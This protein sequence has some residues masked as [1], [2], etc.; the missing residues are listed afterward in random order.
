M[1][2]AQK[3]GVKLKV[4]IL[5]PCFNSIKTIGYT[6]E[7]VL[8]QDY[9]NFEVLVLDGGSD[10]GTQKLVE[11]FKCDNVTIMSRKDR[12]MYDALNNGLLSFTGDAVGVLNSDDRYHDSTVLT[13]IADQLSLFDMVHGHLNFVRDHESGPIIRKWRLKSRPNSGFR[14]GWMPAHP[15][16]YVRRRVAE[17]TGLFNLKYDTAADYDWMLR[18][19]DVEQFSLG[20][21]DH[22]LIDMMIGGKSTAGIRASLQHNLEALQAR[23]HWLNANV[24]DYA[25]FAKPLGKLGQY[26]TSTD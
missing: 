14:S 1:Q 2:L 26:F 18:A 3:L 15:T 24:I 20:E 11:S 17:A 12:G 13:K 8:K 10:D 16:F 5:T 21:V 19:V 4:S 23:R 9:R 6:V 25:F 7:S 22:V